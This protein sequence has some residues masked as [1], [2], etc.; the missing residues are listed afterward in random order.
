MIN[1]YRKNIYGTE[2][3]KLGFWVTDGE[4][5]QHF[6]TT[7]YAPRRFE[8]EVLNKPPF[9]DSKWYKFFNKTIFYRTKE[10]IFMYEAWQEKSEYITEVWNKPEGG[11]DVRHYPKPKKW[12]TVAEVP[13]LSK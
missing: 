1:L 2:D 6:C 4:H 3:F 12:W 9:K 5:Y 8:V 13:A 7:I 10:L 11:Y